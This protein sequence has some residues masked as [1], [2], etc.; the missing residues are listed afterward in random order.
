[1]SSVCNSPEVMSGPLYVTSK[2][3]VPNCCRDSDG[4]PVTGAAYVQGPLNVGDEFSNVEATVMIGELDN[5]QTSSGN[6]SL[7]VEGSQD[8]PLY[9]TGNAFFEHPNIG[10]LS[11]RFNTAD[12]RPKPFDMTHPSKEGWRLRYACIEGPEVGVYFRGRVSGK[13]EIE[14]PWYWKDLV[15]TQS[16]SVQLQPIGAHQDVI[17]KRWD[18]EKIYLQSKGGMPIDCFFHIYGE[19]KDVNGLVVE[20][21]GNT[22]KDYPDPTYHDSNYS[23]KINTPTLDT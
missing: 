2:E 21:P 16:I 11:D 12:A 23:Y 9:V 22:W 20:Y 14:L 13:T 19:R 10:D 1:M 4:K 15:H 8:Y 17:V 5:N 18:E 3:S 6:H 7:Y